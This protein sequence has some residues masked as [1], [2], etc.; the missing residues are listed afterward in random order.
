MMVDV[1]RIRIQWDLI[2]D[3]FCLSLCICLYICVCVVSFLLNQ[4]SSFHFDKQDSSSLILQKCNF[5]R[6]KISNHE[7]S[8]N[9]QIICVSII[10]DISL[11]DAFLN[12]I[13]KIFVSHRSILNKNFQRKHDQEICRAIVISIIRQSFTLHHMDICIVRYLS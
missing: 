7:V 13:V 1:H 3:L 6:N 5:F 2:V 11:D 8:P 4:M 10:N 12:L 9:N